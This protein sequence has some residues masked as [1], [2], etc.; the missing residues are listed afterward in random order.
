[1]RWHL[2]E[3]F[4]S[5]NGK[6]VCLWR[7]VDFEAEVL[8]VLVQSHRKKQAALK[9]IRKLLTSQGFSPDAVVTDKL[10]SYGAAQSDLAMKARHITGGR[11]NNRSENS[12]LPV[13]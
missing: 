2:A 4:V 9:L 7:A 3:V 11:I 13:R 12:P 10:P 5:V 6:S 1:M 8:D